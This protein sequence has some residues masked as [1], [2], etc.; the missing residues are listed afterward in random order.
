MKSKIKVSFVMP[1]Y[2]MT[3]YLP[4]CMDTLLGQTLKE[5][6]IICVDDGSTDDSVALLEQ[7]A[8]KDSRIRVFHNT[9]DGPGAAHP[10]NLG[11]SKAEGEYVLI[12]DSDD[13]FHVDL[14]KKVY[15]KFK[16]SESDI[17]LFNAQWFDA[18]TGE[19]LKDSTTLRK[20]L[21]PDL[22]VFS[23]ADIPGTLFQLS[24]GAAWC[25]GYRRAYLEKYPFYF[26][27]VHVIDDIFF[28][29]TT[30]AMAKKITTLDEK[31]LFY[32]VNN[33]S[34]QVCN[35]ERDATAPIK[36]GALLK[37]WLTAQGVF[38]QYEKTYYVC[39]VM[40]VQLYL[41]SVKTPENLQLLYTTLQKEGLEALGLLTASHEGKLSEF[42]QSW[43]DSIINLSCEAFFQAK[44]ENSAGTITCGTC[45]AIYGYGTRIQSAWETL[46]AQ[47]GVCVAIVDSSPEKLGEVYQ[48]ITITPPNSLKSM[49]VDKVFVSTPFYYEEIRENLLAMGFLEGNIALI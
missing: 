15:D 30:L 3:R 5:I 16:K 4:Q 41:H 24:H 34:S 32:R 7:Y 48:G 23:G 42:A 39:V 43:V 20:D 1:V 38:C 47:G 40:L 12:V 27:S 2:N 29:N 36:V 46:S 6:E 22:E 31:L 33:S 21:L 35:R 17:V 14:A 37:E 26:Q 49:E 18:T 11:L 45:C 19:D 8:S 28:S 9:K 10:R 44:I 13:Y 25:R